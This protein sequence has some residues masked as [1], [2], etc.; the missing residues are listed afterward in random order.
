MHA[1]DAER[2]EKTEADCAAPEETIW[3]GFECSKAYRLAECDQR[4]LFLQMSPEGRINNRSGLIEIELLQRL[5]EP[6]DDQAILHRLSTQLSAEKQFGAAHRR[7]G[8]LTG[9]QFHESFR[10]Q[11]RPPL[12]QI[13]TSIRIQG[14]ATPS[15]RHGE[16]FLHSYFRTNTLV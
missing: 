9:T 2:T 15:G 16:E 13:N 11:S 7:N 5:R 4:P 1:K 3:M 12:Q 10:Q 6:F 8:D 14:Y